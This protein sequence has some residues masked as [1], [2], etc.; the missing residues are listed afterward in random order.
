MKGVTYTQ[1]DEDQL[2]QDAVVR[3]IEVVGEACRQISENF[4]K[5]HPEVPWQ[6]VIGMRNRVT[7]EYFGI[8]LDRVWDIVTVDLPELETH[9]AKWFDEAP[10]DA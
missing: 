9:V 7:H 3:R 8:D 4:K 5:A 2:L 10:D 6:R 1:L